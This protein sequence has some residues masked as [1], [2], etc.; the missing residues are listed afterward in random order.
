MLFRSAWN[1]T[2]CYDS[3]SYFS[4]NPYWLIN[5]QTNNDK[6]HRIFGNIG[7]T[8]NFT[9]QLYI[10]GKIYGDIYALKTEERRA[11]GSKD[12]PYYNKYNTSNS[13]FNYETRLHYNPDLKEF[14][15]IFSVNAFIGMSRTEN[16]RSEEHTSELQ[17]HAYLVCR[18]L[19]ENK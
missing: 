5:K 16:R 10:I 4:D 15:D 17:S 6:N 18:L 1:R 12:T 9:D 14:K 2:T 8:Y 19:L 7:F 13:S 3:D 11:I